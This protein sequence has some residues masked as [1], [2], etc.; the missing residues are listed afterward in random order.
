MDRIAREQDKLELS[1]KKLGDIAFSFLS[2]TQKKVNN[3]KHGRRRLTMSDY[4]QLCRALNLQADRIMSRAL[5]ELDEE[6][7]QHPNN[8]AAAG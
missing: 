6:L 7:S 1:D 4:Y 5:D 2:D 8:K 3:L